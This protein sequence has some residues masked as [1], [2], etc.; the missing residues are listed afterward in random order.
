[1]DNAVFEF[2][3]GECNVDNCHKLLEEAGLLSRGII[4]QD[5][6]Y[7]TSVEIFSRIGGGREIK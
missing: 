2:H 7:R 4:K 5:P 6:V 1:V 3:A